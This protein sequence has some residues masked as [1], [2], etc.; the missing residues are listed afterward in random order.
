MIISTWNI[1]GLNKPYKQK[2]LRNFLQKNKVDILGCLETR[3]KEKKAKNILQKV[4]K[5]WRYCCNYSKGENGRICILWRTSLAVKIVHIHEQFI[6]CLVDDPM[7]SIQIMVT[8][9]YARNK[10]QERAILWHDLQ[11]IGGQTQIPW[12]ISGD[13]N[14]LLTTDDRQGQLVTASEVQEFKQCISNMQ[15][16]P[17]RTKG[18][19]FTWCNKQ[20]AHA[21]VYSKIDWA[22]GN[23]KWTKDYGHVEAD[24]LEPG[25]SDHSPILVQVW[26]RR[27]IHP[28]PFKLYMVTM[29]HKDFR[30]MV[31]RIWQQ[32][33]EMDP[34]TS[35]WQKLHKLKNESKGLN[36]EMANYEQRLTTIRQRLECIQANMV[37]DPFNQMLIEQE[38]QTMHELEKWSIIEERI[39]R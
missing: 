23:F 21:R 10:L 18:C 3:V 16:T 37:H 2:E 36:K 5:D 27:T 15:L 30:P 35:I 32:Q 33:N 11:Q 29:E 17:L 9:V 4:A 26:K 12:L 38:K 39:L 31:D 1:R 7:T 20:D 13:F 14:N 19:F 24:C 28:K 25:V 34:M 22:F 6:E 8:V